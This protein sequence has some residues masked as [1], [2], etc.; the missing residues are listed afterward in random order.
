MGY[1][2]LHTLNMLIHNPSQ[3]ITQVINAIPGVTFQDKLNHLSNCHCCYRHQVNKPIILA[4]WI[5]TYSNNILIIYPCQCNCRHLARLIC[6]QI[7]NNTPPSTPPN[8]P[9]NVIDF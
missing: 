2:R 4:P 7:N 6:R 3:N 8:S 1:I 9:T 5:D